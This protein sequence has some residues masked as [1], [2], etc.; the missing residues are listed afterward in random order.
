MS[1]TQPSG[2]GEKGWLR[3]RH[4]SV[5]DAIA[6]LGVSRSGPL[7][8]RELEG[9]TN[10]HAEEE[11]FQ[12]SKQRAQKLEAL[13]SGSLVKSEVTAELQTQMEDAQKQLQK[14]HALA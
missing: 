12:E 6:T 2:T 14:M 4:A 3:K 11:A 9:W 8:P 1:L 5:T 7:A 10:S 13:E